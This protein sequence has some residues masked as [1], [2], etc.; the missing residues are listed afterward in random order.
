MSLLRHADRVAIACVAQLAN[1]IA[2]IRV[3]SSGAWRQTIFYP[4]ALTAQYA[5]GEVLRAQATS[6][7]YETAYGEVGVL[8]VVGTLDK[9][10]GE[11]TVFAANR[12]RDRAMSL[13]VDLRASP[14]MTLAD[15]RLLGGSA[16]SDT[17]TEEH[18]ERVVPRRG[19]GA[20]IVGN[21][22]LVSL[23]PVSWSMLRAAPARP[24]S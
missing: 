14:A 4:F 6:P 5:R 1:V 2:P 3:E 19:A 8:D 10:T 12:D 23:P 17:N 7:T 9:S 18:P 22:L 24:A 15:H 11:L 13:D 21:R 20:E 16:L